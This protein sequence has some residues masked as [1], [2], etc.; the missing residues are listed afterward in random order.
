MEIV[1]SVCPQNA[2]NTRRG[3]GH[4]ALC[5]QTDSHLQAD[6]EPSSSGGFRISDR[7]DIIPR[8]PVVGSKRGDDGGGRQ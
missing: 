5:P 2:V 8:P 6:D 4:Y 1:D 3:R 7:A